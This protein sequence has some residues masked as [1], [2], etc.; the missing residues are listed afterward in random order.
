MKRIMTLTTMLML[1]LTIGCDAFKGG[2]EETQKNPPRADTTY[3]QAETVAMEN[4]AE[5]RGAVDQALDWADKY[6]K[7]A[8]NLVYANQRIQELEAEKAELAKQQVALKKEME[9]YKKE[10]QDAHA[11]LD[12]MK[13]DLNDWRENVLGYRKEIMASQAAQLKALQKILE[14]LGGEVRT[15]SK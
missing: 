10:L 7:A 5:R 12:E 14:L 2:Y 11:M 13:K 6:A 4:D 3:L 1:G 9:Q 8:Q 15:A